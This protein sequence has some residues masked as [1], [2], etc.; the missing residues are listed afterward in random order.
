MIFREMGEGDSSPAKTIVQTD[1][2]SS[3]QRC[4]IP[5]PCSLLIAHYAPLLSASMS[6]FSFSVGA[7]CK[8]RDT[9][10]SRNKAPNA[11]CTEN[12]NKRLEQG[13]VIMIMMALK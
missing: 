7:V 10:M 12:G 9:E 6:P 11:K 1:K 5:T 2:D 8:G 13:K 4:V 3:V